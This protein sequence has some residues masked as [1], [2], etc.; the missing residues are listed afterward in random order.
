MSLPRR[1]W[2]LS[3]D[4]ALFLLGFGGVLHETLVANVER[5]SLL[6]L[7]GACLGLPAFLSADR[8]ARSSSED[9]EPPAP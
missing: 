3:R 7:F 5:P 2:R 4:S 8:R 6:I 9:S 1:W